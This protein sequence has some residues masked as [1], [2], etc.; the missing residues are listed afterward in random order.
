MGVGRRTGQAVFLAAAA[1][2]LCGCEAILGW[3]YDDGGSAD[4]VIAES[5][6]DPAAPAA[7][8]NRT[9]LPQCPDM[10]LML[11]QEPGPEGLECLQHGY[12]ND[13]AELAIARSTVEG[14]MVV[15][16]HRV[17]AGAPELQTFHDAT[18]DRFGSGA[19]EEFT[20]PLPAG[21]DSIAG[22]I[23]P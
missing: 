10:V 23:G 5:R 15:S 13:G 20:C 17:E 6:S 19:W 21:A 2:M 16:F 12:L 7:F 11:G 4:S 1:V 3:S 9:P 8:R 22:C 14:D 18:R